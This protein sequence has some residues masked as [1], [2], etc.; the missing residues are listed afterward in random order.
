MLRYYFY[1][2]IIP[3]ENPDKQPTYCLIFETQSKFF[4][5]DLIVFN[6]YLAF[7]N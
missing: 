4:A 3:N 2:V 1:E 7:Y 6:R 5:T